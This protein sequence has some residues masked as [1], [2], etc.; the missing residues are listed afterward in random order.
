VDNTVK[1][2]EIA[3]KAVQKSGEGTS[4]VM[5]FITSHKKG[6]LI[7][8]AIGV[9]FL[10]FSS[11]LSSCSLM[12][13]SVTSS[14]VMTTYPSEDADMLDAEEQYK[15]KENELQEYLDNYESSHDYDEYHFELDEIEHDPYVLISMPTAMQEGGWKID[16]VESLLQTIFDK[17]YILTEN[18]EV[19]T[20]YRT[21]TETYTDED[22][23]TLGE[24]YKTTFKTKSAKTESLVTT[25]MMVVMFA[26]I[27]VFTLRDQA[28]KAREAAEEEAKSGKKKPEKVNP[29]KDA[30][31]EAERIRAQKKKEKEMKVRE[32][33]R[34]N[35]AKERAKKKHK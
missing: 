34:K 16:E 18:V 25:G 9:L 17:Q 3:A 4:R 24:E 15:A 30:K 27:I 35:E 7:L 32:H 6:F 10:M 11:L 12:M 31:K 2:S 20:R 22:G 19:E 8:L 29:Y 1:A 28:K 33:M 13:S 26:G 5:Q 23:N 14:G 21:E